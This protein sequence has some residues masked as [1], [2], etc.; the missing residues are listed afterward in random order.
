M[1]EPKLLQDRRLQQQL[2]FNMGVRLPFVFW[3]TT[4]FL[5]SVLSRF[6]LVELGLGHI[7]I[8]I[9]LNYSLMYFDVKI[10]LS[11]QYSS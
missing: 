9:K 3:Q 2:L 7:T 6:C 11:G 10:L 4:L 5:C 1:Q 8:A